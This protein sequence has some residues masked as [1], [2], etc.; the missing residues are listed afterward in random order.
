MSMNDEGSERSSGSRIQE[1]TYSQT[2]GSTG[3]GSSLAEKSRAAGATLKDKARQTKDRVMNKGSDTLQQ[4][5]EKSR[6]FAD[7][8]KNQ[9]GE[10]IHGYGS[11][12]HRAAEKLRDEQD[13]NIAY[14][15]DMVAEKFDQAADYLQSRDPG[16]I[17]RDIENA[18]R[19]RPEIFFG[20][21]FLAGLV[22]ARFLKASGERHESYSESNEDY[23]VEEPYAG[24]TDTGYA[25]YSTQEDMP[26]MATSPTDFGGEWKGSTQPGGNI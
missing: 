1:P 22:L 7:D 11:A 10:R 14:Y 23:W 25:G 6:T 20:G 19:R 12:V 4:A 3:S 13:P 8:R 18:A 17:F 16:A 5:R 24:A 9:L 21:M 2:P 26:H 15:A